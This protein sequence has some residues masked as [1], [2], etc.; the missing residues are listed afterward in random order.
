V[1][2]TFNPSDIFAMTSAEIR[3][4]NTATNA[5]DVDTVAEANIISTDERAIIDADEPKVK[6]ALVRW[7]KGEQFHNKCSTYGN[8]TYSSNFHF[9]FSNH[10]RFPVNRNFLQR[11]VFPFLEAS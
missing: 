7:A 8:M 1:S 4:R 2:K 3:K 6:V 11:T 5:S 9:C 10:Y